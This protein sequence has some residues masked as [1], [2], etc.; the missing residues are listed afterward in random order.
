MKTIKFL[1]KGLLLIAGAG[2]AMWFFMPWKQVGESLLLAT[3]RRLQLSVTYSFV[4]D[5]PGGFVVEDLSVRNFMG[6][7]D[8]SIRTLMIVPDLAASLLNMAPTCRISFTGG[9]LGDV[10]VTPLR[11]IPGVTIGNGRV[12][13]SISA[14][15]VLL[16]GLR[17]NGELSMNGTLLIA[18]S[19]Y[20]P[21]RWADVTIDVKSE[22]FEQEMPALGNLL[23]L[24]QESPGRWLLRRAVN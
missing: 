5:A 6:V 10:A 20:P 22:S 21:I 7:M 12:M 1:L 11:K 13:V 8:G 24:R 9:V 18:S 2:M 15:G 16:E 17:S 4:G 3:I 19:A 14:Q 23:P